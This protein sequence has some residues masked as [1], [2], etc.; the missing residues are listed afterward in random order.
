MIRFADVLNE[1]QISK[2]FFVEMEENF[3]F[4]TYVCLRSRPA[5]AA[6]ETGKTSLDAESQVL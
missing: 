2:A 3:Y 5:G 4:L 1:Q 6:S